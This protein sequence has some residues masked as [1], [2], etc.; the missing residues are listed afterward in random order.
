MP[1][2]PRPPA[3][4]APS[5]YF[6]P[7]TARLSPEEQRLARRLPVKM[8]DLQLQFL[9]GAGT[10]SKSSLDEGSALLVEILIQQGDF[11]DAARVCDLGCG[12]GAVGAL[13]A[14][15]HPAHSV[16]SLDINPRAV[17]LAGLN[18]AHNEIE[19]AV[20]WCG[21]GLGAARTEFFDC[22]AFN[23]P[24][25]AGNQVIER[26]FR[27]A[28]GSLKAGGQLWAVIRTSQGAKTWAKKLETLF[29]S[30]ETV[31]MRGGYRI[32]KATK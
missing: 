8:G 3:K 12:W 31:E 6:S 22:V 10:F 7:D 4:A 19:N 27:D 11:P 14:K 17:Q 16:Y 26:L 23:P 30:C 20:A 32:L 1:V 15:T 21:D 5:H 28:H 2:R 29:G 13:W 24:I 9:T 18:F 25:R